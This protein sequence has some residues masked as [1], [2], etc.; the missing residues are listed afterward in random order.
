MKNISTFLVSLAVF[1][2][3]I[4]SVWAQKPVTIDVSKLG[5][6]DNEGNWSIPD[7]SHW[8]CDGNALHLQTENGQ[9]TL[10]GTNTNLI[11]LVNADMNVTLNNVTIAVVGTASNTCL[12]TLI[13]SNTLNTFRSDSICTITSNTNG[14]L[15]GIK[16]DHRSFE[17]YGTFSITGNATVSAISNHATESGMLVST[18][19]NTTINI[20]A[21]ATLNVTGRYT[22]LQVFSG[23]AFT[24]NCDGSAVI[25]ASTLIG[26]SGGS[27][28]TPVTITG[29][30]T[31]SIEG[32]QYGF[33]TN[34]GSLAVEDC[35]VTISGEREVS[36]Y[37]N[38]NI[39]MN[40]A[41]KLTIKSGTGET[42][43]FEKSNVASTYK[44]KLTNATTSDPLTN[45]A[46]NVTV[47]AGQTG[48]VERT[49]GTGIDEWIMEKEEWI[50]YP[51]P[52]DDR[53]NF[54]IETPYEITDL[55]GRS[56]LK[57]DKAVKS[58][59]I[60]GLPSG[61][62][63]VIVNTETGKTVKKIIKK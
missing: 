48:K 10:T 4:S 16:P 46:I 61:T 42:H 60:T 17:I 28:S 57:S 32:E 25:K 58:V 35:N 23:Y 14:S 56:L 6:E 37:T 18:W 24:L 9:Y 50:I 51:N 29:K 1:G 20:G 55:Q 12:I 30:G 31:V 54:S 49:T 7:E 39:K 43:K 19:G 21:N 41:A 34:N 22:G 15:T 44:W 40:D 47:D 36:I 2:L 62:Y 52:V 3:S 59:N 13:G 11:V 33:Y 8:N 27:G 38:N 26:M 45:A 53:L 63:F 5:G